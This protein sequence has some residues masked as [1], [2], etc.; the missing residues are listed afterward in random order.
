MGF[1]ALPCSAFQFPL[2]TAS[3]YVKT[4]VSEELRDPCQGEKRGGLDKIHTPVMCIV[5][6]T[7]KDTNNIIPRCL[8]ENAR[9]AIITKG[10]PQRPPGNRCFVFINFYAIIPLFDMYIL[11][12][13]VSSYERR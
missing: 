6:N 3:Y 13:A 9:A 11:C 10:A 7:D 2:T 5:Y 8:E 12:N 4:V 1:I